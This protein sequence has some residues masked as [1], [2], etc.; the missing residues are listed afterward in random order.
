[1]ID[2]VIVFKA[3]NLPADQERE[4]FTQLARLEQV[5][6][7]Q[8]FALG[9][10]VGDRSRGF[11]ICLRATFADRAALDAYE[12]HPLHLEVVAYNRQVTSEHLC[13]DFAWDEAADD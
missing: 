10:N 1:M 4:L 8:G 9:K 3:E 13:V 7:V 12:A 6:G 11:D 2:H 5:P